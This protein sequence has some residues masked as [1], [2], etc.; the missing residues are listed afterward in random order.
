MQPT[1]SISWRLVCSFPIDKKLPVLLV[2]LAI[3]A[4]AS[5]SYVFCFLMVGAALCLLITCK[6]NDVDEQCGLVSPC[7]V[8]VLPL[9]ILIRH[10]V[11][12]TLVRIVAGSIIFF[13][14]YFSCLT[15][16]FSRVS[17]MKTCISSHQL[18]QDYCLFV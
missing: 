1:N 10:F 4:I 2:K 17:T 12:S 16:I 18:L 6:E 8:T 14:S 7:V 11:T 15:G 13:S 5:L 3:R 9:T